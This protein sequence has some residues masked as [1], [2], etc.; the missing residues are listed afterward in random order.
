M[1][2]P[3]GHPEALMLGAHLDDWLVLQATRLHPAP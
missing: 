2:D 3:H 1:T